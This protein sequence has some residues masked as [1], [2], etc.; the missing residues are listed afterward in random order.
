MLAEKFFL[1]L[2]TIRSRSHPD[3][4]PIVVSTSRHVP[5][6]LPSGNGKQA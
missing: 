2:E 1:L 5:I 3:G 6:K 4:S